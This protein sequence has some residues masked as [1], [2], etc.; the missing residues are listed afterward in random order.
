MA[1]IKKIFVHNEISADTIRA[2][3]RGAKLKRYLVNIY[4]KK[5]K[6]YFM[7]IIIDWRVNIK[8]EHQT[9]ISFPLNKV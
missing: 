8:Q 2:T 9:V 1:Y 4:K 3:K 5:G 6:F 7:F